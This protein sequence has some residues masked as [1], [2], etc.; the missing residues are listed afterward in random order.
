MI[1]PSNAQ[2][3]KR[4]FN[5]LIEDCFASRDERIARYDRW[6]SLY[7]FG[8]ADGKA[9][10]NKL[11]SHL[12]DVTSLLFSSE[13]VRFSFT[14]GGR[15]ER[16]EPWMLETASE[17]LAGIWHDESMGVTFGDCL[18][19]S[20]VYGTVILAPQWR[21][22]GLQ[23]YEIA[24]W[25]F[26]V[27]NEQITRLDRQEAV[28]LAYT[29]S[30]PEFLRMLPPGADAQAILRRVT[31]RPQ[32]GET[33]EAQIPNTILSNPT[34]SSN[35]TGT[36]NPQLSDDPYRPVVR[37]DVIQMRDLYVWDDDENVMRVVT[38][39]EPDVFIFDRKNMTTRSRLPFVALTPNPLPDYFWGE[40][41]I[42]FLS[43]LQEWRNKRFS[44]MDRLLR[45]QENPPKILAGFQGITDEKA[46][47]LSNEGAV[48]SSNIP[49]AKVQELSPQLP[50]NAMQEIAEL[51]AMFQVASGIPGQLF[52]SNPPNVRSHSQA[53]SAAILAS[54]RP[55]RRAIRIE[56]A[57]NNLLALVIDILRQE[58]A[59]QY[60]GDSGQP[61]AIGSLPLTAQV[62]VDGH[63]SSPVFAMQNQMI[64]T[65]LFEAGAIDAVSLLEML[66]PPMLDTL[67]ARLKKKMQY[68]AQHPEAAQPEK[69]AKKK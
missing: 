32:E 50:V 60:V 21:K 66:N 12:E 4:I 25:N 59:T 48:I 6:R 62:K 15:A 69:K 39:A 22:S 8:A 16:G 29:I 61:M 51:D 13:S 2:A 20:F 52:G 17:A 49:G 11:R 37:A 47:A 58:D 57:L 67:K 18:P 40:S 55:K 10:F 54:A 5:R 24:P 31:A 14:W 38:R 35:Y 53:S 30:V 34:G 41:E 64:T 44:Q 3:R 23:L 26:G 7:L 45:R 36:T 43:G 56:A 46:K 1:L 27:A 42:E 9:R 65:E 68:M 19:W 33:S 63:S 28:C